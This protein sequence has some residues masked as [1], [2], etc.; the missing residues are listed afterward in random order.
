MFSLLTATMDG[1]PFADMKGAARTPGLSH[2][3]VKAKK[4]AAAFPARGPQKIRECG[5]PRQKPR[6]DSRK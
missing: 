5:R 6:K 4:P 1:D 3:P 2:L